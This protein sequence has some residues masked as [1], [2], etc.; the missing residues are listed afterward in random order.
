MSVSCDFNGT[1]GQANDSGEP[2]GLLF[3]GTPLAVHLRS[4]AKLDPRLAVGGDADDPADASGKVLPHIY[5][6]SNLAE[7]QMFALGIRKEHVAVKGVGMKGPTG[8]FSF[9]VLRDLAPVHAT[10]F[11]YA[12]NKDMHPEFKQHRSQHY[13]SYSSL[14]VAHGPYKTVQGMAD[15][16]RSCQVMAYHLHGDE[17]KFWQNWRSMPDRSEATIRH[18]LEAEQRAGHIAWLS[19]R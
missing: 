15:L 2:P 14:N 3:H 4:P 8:D 7:A 9:L 18:T 11:V 13:V 5:I 10:G 17:N 12:F 16:T 19:F 1:R 6:T